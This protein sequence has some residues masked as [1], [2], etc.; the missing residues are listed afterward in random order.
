VS[1]QTEPAAVRPEIASGDGYDHPTGRSVLWVSRA[2]GY[3]VYAYLLFVET[4]LFLGF[5]LLLAGANP[6]SP[7]VEWVYRSLD[8]VMEPFRGIFTPIQLGMTGGNEV[9]SIFETSVLFAMI[10]YGIVAMV[11][12]ALIG[13]LSTRMA[14]LDRA[15]RERRIRAYAERG[16]AGGAPPHGTS[17]P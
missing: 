11:I 17:A 12:H 13:W 8:R 2:I 6:S 16:A 10:I 4:I 3:L 15:S 5:F 7:F 14:D 1:H 9:E